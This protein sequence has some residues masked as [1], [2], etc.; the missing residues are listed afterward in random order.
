MSDVVSEHI[1][2]DATYDEDDRY[3]DELIRNSAEDEANAMDASIAMDAMDAMEK[4]DA[5]DALAAKLKSDADKMPPPP[6][7]LPEPD[8]DLGKN[9]FKLFGLQF[10]V[11]G[12]I[13]ATVEYKSV[14]SSMV[15]FVELDMT[16]ESWILRS[17]VTPASIKSIWLL[18]S[19]EWKSR[20]CVVLRGIAAA[21]LTPYIQAALQVKQP[22]LSTIVMNS[23]FPGLVRN[24]FTNPYFGAMGMESEAENWHIRN[25]E[26]KALT[27][28]ID[29]DVA[30]K[31]TSELS[32]M[33]E[34]CRTMHSVY[35]RSSR[36]EHNLPYFKDVVP[37][38]DNPF[39]L[40]RCVLA[41]Y[42]YIV[43][44]DA[45][46]ATLK[47]DKQILT[48]EVRILRKAVADC[49]DSAENR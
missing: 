25:N 22:S 6:P 12:G 21:T 30:I 46:S 28:K 2:E 3:F 42:V 47:G 34:N 18:H 33:Y 27:W 37:T 29:T 41:L 7:R 32:K 24:S 11:G 26:I 40:E 31:Y 43:H 44:I 13:E 16:S 35:A 19:G 5:I 8:Y 9:P 17:G 4:V 49:L 1:M 38:D 23:Y 15:E 20:S 48:N 39:D 36:F 14:E 45:W 10:V